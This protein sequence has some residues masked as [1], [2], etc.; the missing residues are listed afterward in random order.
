MS[1]FTQH[2]ALVKSVV[3]NQ[4]GD[5]MELFA[6]NKITL[7]NRTHGVLLNRVQEADQYE[8]A[9]FTTELKVV[10]LDVAMQPYVKA[11]N[12]LKHKGVWY[13]FD[14]PTD[15]STIARGAKTDAHFIYWY[16]K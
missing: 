5:Q 6:A 15:V 16:V 2:A 4:F 3:L 10:K 12:W 11:N 7:L 13:K 14:Q 1:R 8:D 9:R